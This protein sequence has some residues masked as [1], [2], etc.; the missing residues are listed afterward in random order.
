MPWCFLG[1]GGG[2]VAALGMIIITSIELKLEK[3]RRGTAAMA[4]VEIYFFD[5][6]TICEIF[7]KENSLRHAKP[8]KRNESQLKLA[9]AVIIG[10]ALD[11]FHERGAVVVIVNRNAELILPRPALE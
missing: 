11:E 7:L 6:E 1:D 9:G 4:D 2:G 3:K 10:D 5:P 8:Q